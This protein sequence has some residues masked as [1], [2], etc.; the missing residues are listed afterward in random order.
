MNVLYEQLGIG[1]VCF[2]FSAN[3]HTLGN[4]HYVLCLIYVLEHTEGLSGF[5]KCVE[6][7]SLPSDSLNL[8][9]F[10]RHISS[11]RF[12]IKRF[13]HPKTIKIFGGSF[14]QRL[15]IFFLMDSCFDSSI[16]HLSIHPF[17]YQT[18]KPAIIHNI[19]CSPKFNNHMQ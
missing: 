19:V 13:C 4:K 16:L 7:S 8:M 14:V 2:V 1:G 17:M 18:G 10:A 5:H 6:C 3:A 12:R 15:G 9:S 11:K